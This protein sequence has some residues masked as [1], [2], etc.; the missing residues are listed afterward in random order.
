MKAGELCNREVGIIDGEAT[1]LEAAERMRELHTGSLVVVGDAGRVRRPVGLITD[2][3][4][5]ISVLATDPAGAGSL[6]VEEVM[7]T[8]V[9]TAREDQDVSEVI[10]AMRARGVRRVP[11]VDAEG[12]LQGILA[13]DDLLEWVTEQLTDLAKLVERE[14]TRERL[15]GR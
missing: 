4:L 6:T 12:G 13:L 1:V 8:P 2:R 14:Q 10:P 15:Q 9:L 7:S 5:V 3:D 11:V